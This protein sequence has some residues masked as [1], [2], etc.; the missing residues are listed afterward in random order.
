MYFSIRKTLALRGIRFRFEPF[1]K[2]IFPNPFHGNEPHMARPKKPAHER[3]TENMN[4]FVTDLERVQIEHAAA[5]HGLGLSEFF[6][7]RSLSVRLPAA[8]VENQHRAEAT[9]ALLRLGVNL[10]QIAKHV[11][12]GQG[13]AVGELN[14]LIV[15]INV[16]MDNLMRDLD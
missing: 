12:A 13:V 4:F 10:N 2:Q 5:L 3:R 8:A 6:R 16:E 14:A 7:R 1:G 9:T 11:N 15:R